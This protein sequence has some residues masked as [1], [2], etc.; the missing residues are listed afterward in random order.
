MGLGDKTKR[1]PKII[2]ED[3]EN[4]DKGTYGRHCS[5]FMLRLSIHTYLKLWLGGY[6]FTSEFYDKER[7]Y[8][9][10]CPTRIL[11][12]FQ[13]PKYPKINYGPLGVVPSLIEYK[14]FL[15]KSMNN[16]DDPA[17]NI[18]LRPTT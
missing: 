18:A 11:L 16:V 4:G 14:S 2:S 13:Y 3:G 1:L 15:L 7:E 17:V 9:F 8:N 10:E 12:E 5:N 6:E